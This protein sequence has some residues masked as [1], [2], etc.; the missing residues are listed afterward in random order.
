MGAMYLNKKGISINWE[1]LTFFVLWEVIYK[2]I[3]VSTYI[4][5]QKLYIWLY[6]DFDMISVA[7]LCSCTIGNYCDVY[8]SFGLACYYDTIIV[9]LWALLYIVL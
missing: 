8:Y 6:I 2:Y 7:D 1:I 4:G 9:Y 5:S 3:Y